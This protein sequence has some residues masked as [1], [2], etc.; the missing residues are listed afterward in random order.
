MY[1]VGNMCYQLVSTVIERIVC[2]AI[3]SD[4]MLLLGDR[5][6]INSSF[7]TGSLFRG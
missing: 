7:P 2:T 4:V 6:G 1:F 3:H 5:K